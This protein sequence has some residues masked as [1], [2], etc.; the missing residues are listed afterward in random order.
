M[1]CINDDLNTDEHKARHENNNMK[2]YISRLHSQIATPKPTV[3]WNELSETLSLWSISTQNR[4][5]HSVR[6]GFDLLSTM[7]G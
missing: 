7:V 4:G 6:R 5:F 2:R 1:T 3:T